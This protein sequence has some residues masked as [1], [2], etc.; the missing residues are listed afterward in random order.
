M[1]HKKLNKNFFH[2][3]LNKI[4]LFYSFYTKTINYT[5]SFRKD[6]KNHC[7]QL[8]QVNDFESVTSVFGVPWGLLLGVGDGL[9]KVEWSSTRAFFLFAH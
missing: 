5:I 3:K 6:Y 8:Q 9:V 1:L 7:V 4:E 2:K